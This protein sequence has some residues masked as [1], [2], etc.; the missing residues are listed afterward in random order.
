MMS[1]SPGPTQ[2][3]AAGKILGVARLLL[4]LPRT[5]PAH[6]LRTRVLVSLTLLFSSHKVLFALFP[7]FSRSAIR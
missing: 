4:L 7:P 1:C 6:T 3:T 5:G 2:V